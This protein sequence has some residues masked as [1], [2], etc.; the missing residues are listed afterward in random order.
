MKKLLT[1]YDLPKPLE[2]LYSMT[3]KEWWHD[4]VTIKMNQLEHFLIVCDSLKQVHEQ[5]LSNITTY[6]EIYNI[7]PT[8]D[9]IIYAIL[10]LLTLSNNADFIHYTTNAAG[11]LC[12][13]LHLSRLKISTS[14]K[15][16]LSSSY[17]IKKCKNLLTYQPGECLNGWNIRTKVRYG[18]SLLI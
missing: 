3:A 5:H 2:L 1:L 18:H 4:C 10:D 6:M 12:F 17:K 14:K 16:S 13:N 7:V 9:N 15:M 11:T 8:H